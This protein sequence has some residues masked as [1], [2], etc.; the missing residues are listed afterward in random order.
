MHWLTIIV[1][2]LMIPAFRWLA[3]LMI[4]ILGV[5]IWMNYHP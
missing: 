2:L 3:K 5:T 1:V 4:L